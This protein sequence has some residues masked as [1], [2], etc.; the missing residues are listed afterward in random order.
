MSILLFHENPKIYTRPISL[1]LE[2]TSAPWLCHGP[3]EKLTSMDLQKR[4]VC[5][6]IPAR[7]K[8]SGVNVKNLFISVTDAVLQ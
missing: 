8:E 6:E 5:I 1:S 3:L 4:I 2:H 7:Q